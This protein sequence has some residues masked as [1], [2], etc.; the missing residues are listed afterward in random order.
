MGLLISKYASWRRPGVLWKVLKFV[1]ICLPFLA[2]LLWNN[3]RVKDWQNETVLL[4]RD[5][6]NFPK[7]VKLHMLYANLLY[8]R[9]AGDLNLERKKALLE[10]SLHHYQKT[11]RLYPDHA[12]AWNNLGT[13]YA[14]YY[15]QYARALEAYG[16]AISIEPNYPIAEFGAGYC[17]EKLG[18][19]SEA[20]EH[21][22]QAILLQAGLKPAVEGRK[23]VSQLLDLE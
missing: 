2:A 10:T 3:I 7:S 21:Y 22:G 1:L 15:G 12:F 4:K 18:R 13:L 20:L 8:K 17:L 14:D 9:I 16:R 5:V 19:F 6:E 23:R 11:I